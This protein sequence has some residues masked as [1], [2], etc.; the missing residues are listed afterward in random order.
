MIEIL[1]TFGN[2]VKN[3]YKSV[4]LWIFIIVFCWVGYHLALSI[5]IYINS[6]K[7]VGYEN[8]INSKEKLINDNKFASITLPKYTDYDIEMA[9]PSGQILHNTVQG[10]WGLSTDSYNKGATLGVYRAGYSADGSIYQGPSGKRYK[11]MLEQ[12]PYTLKYSFRKGSKG[13]DVKIFVNDNLVHDLKN[14]GVTSDKF[15]V[16][17]TNY[18]SFNKETVNSNRGRRII[19]YIKFIPMINQDKDSFSN[20]NV[21]NIEQFIVKEAFESG[22]S[23]EMQ[24]KNA[25]NIKEY[26]DYIKMLNTYDELEETDIKQS[27]K[28]NINYLMDNSWRGYEHAASPAFYGMHADI[29]NGMSYDNIIQKYKHVIHDKTLKGNGKKGGDYY[30]HLLSDSKTIELILNDLDDYNMPV[31]P[32]SLSKMM[33]KSNAI[34]ASI[35]F[36]NSDSAWNDDDFEEDYDYEDM[37]NQ[38]TFEK[39][40]YKQVTQ[41][42][43]EKNKEL[44]QEEQKKGELIMPA[45]N[46]NNTS[47]K[48]GFCPKNC[49][50]TT[51][52][53]GNCDKDIIR[54]VVDG[55]DKFYRKCPYRCKN[56]S[57]K[58][59]VN[60]DKS[61]PDNPYDVKR[62]GCRYSQAHCAENCSQTLVEV[63]EQGRDLNHLPNNYATINAN[64]SKIYG[65]KETTGIFGITDNRLGGSKTA[66]K[67]DYK[68]LNPNPK[69]GPINYDAIWDFKA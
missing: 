16:V 56:R 32:D 31:K 59:Y 9:I 1:N 65:K 44:N 69:I 33:E 36:D 3:L 64:T 45:N 10:N 66:Y 63:D 40:L 38:D 41:R 61:G 51:M 5:S 23:L 46:P 15:K 49:V 14:E 4:E 34:I 53:D 55:E 28:D 39:P 18:A 29:A 17:G 43:N 7:R 48:G 47:S 26:L 25:D 50:K 20:M 57:E 52:I 6:K 42:E 22:I 19:D 27:M 35:T 11:R 58:D 21:Y 24:K 12:G 60:H 54:M 13:Q 30:N 68:P 8:F 67:T 37:E 2:T 62:D